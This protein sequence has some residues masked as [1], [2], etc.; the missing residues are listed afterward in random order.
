[1]FIFAKSSFAFSEISQNVKIHS[2]S[3]HLKSTF[4]AAVFIKKITWKQ[5]ILLQAVFTKRIELRVDVLTFEKWIFL[6]TGFNIIIVRVQRA[7]DPHQLEFTSKW[8]Q[9]QSLPAKHGPHEAL[10]HQNLK[11]KTNLENILTTKLFITTQMRLK[12]GSSGNQMGLKWN[13]NGKWDSNGP[14]WEINEI[15]QLSSWFY[16]T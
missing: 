1:M 12:W 9:H 15:V 16:I 5:R 7:S 10:L 13:S 6:L 4:P 2:R 11:L 8:V 14:K 3:F